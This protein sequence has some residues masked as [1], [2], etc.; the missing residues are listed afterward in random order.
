MSIIFEYFNY[1]VYG[2]D[3]SNK[4]P[5]TIENKCLITP[6]DL[7][8]VNLNPPKDIIP[9]PTRNMP[10]TFT[11]VDLRNLNKAQLNQILNVKL[12]PIPIK[13]KINFY[14]HRHPVLKELYNKFNNKLT[15]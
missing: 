10:P 2:V 13:E 14:E 1:Y 12:K 3:D 11:T 9:S 8:S 4:K 7:K 6:D 5:S 15:Q